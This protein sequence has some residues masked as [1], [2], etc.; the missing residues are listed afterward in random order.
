MTI[1]IN[2]AKTPG[3]QTVIW[4]SA[5][6]LFAGMALLV[7]GCETLGRPDS[8]SLDNQ[9]AQLKKNQAQLQK[10]MAEIKTL[11]RQQPATPKRPPTARTENIPL[12]GISFLG[13]TD[14]PITIVE[15]TD[16][17]CPFCRRHAQN[18]L[19]LL[20]KQYID[21]GKVRYGIREFPLQDLHPKAFRLSEAALCAGD[22]GKY[23]E[24]HDRL[25]NDTAVAS[26]KT[27]EGGALGLD[28]EEFTQCMNTNMHA[29][30]IRRDLASGFALGVRGT[31]YFLMGLTDHEDDK[32]L[33]VA[34]TLSGA[35]PFL[36]FQSEIERLITLQKSINE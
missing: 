10:D 2:K 29:D 22:Q 13:K 19:P 1:L 18:T 6:L 3:P 27:A 20:L 4:L 36:R 24:M 16:Y 14:A 17:Q 32:Q 31:P 7:S 30:K 28:A 11:L 26:D 12:N 25:M 23:W 9:V 35:Q 33:H 21:T 34:T 8:P 15:Y 5:V